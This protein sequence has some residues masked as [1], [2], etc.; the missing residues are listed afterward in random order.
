M[1]SNFNLDPRH[2]RNRS[3]KISKRSREYLPNPALYVSTPPLIEPKESEPKPKKRKITLSRR[4][5]ENFISGLGFAGGF[6][7]FAVIALYLLGGRF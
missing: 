3:G 4:F 7:A 6:L 5:L 2:P 1:P